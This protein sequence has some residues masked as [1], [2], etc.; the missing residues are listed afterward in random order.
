[1]QASVVEEKELSFDRVS[2]GR[3][4]D[5]SGSIP[6]AGVPEKIDVFPSVG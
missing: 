6:L 4:G 3:G 5:G 2:R 1:M